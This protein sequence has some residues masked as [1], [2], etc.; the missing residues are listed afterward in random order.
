MSFHEYMRRVLLSRRG[1]TK[2]RHLQ[3]CDGYLGLFGPSMPLHAFPKGGRVPTHVAR[4]TCGCSCGLL[5][6]LLLLVLLVLVLLVLVLLVLLVLLLLVLLV[7]VL[8][9]TMMLATSMST[10][11]NAEEDEEQEEEEGGCLWTEVRLQV[12]S[13]LFFKVQCQPC[14]TGVTTMDWVSESFNSN[15]GMYEL[16]YTGPYDGLTLCVKN[17]AAQPGSELFPAAPPLLPRPLP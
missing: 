10:T 6:N 1:R 5:G 8:A 4:R 12:K 2:C 3:V 15:I 11:N 9:K 7:L 13:S 17:E 14:N 16:S